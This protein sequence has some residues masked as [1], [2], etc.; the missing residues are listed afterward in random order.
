M[1]RDLN[2]CSIDDSSVL[3]EMRQDRFSH[4]DEAKDI[5]AKRTFQLFW[6]E[7]FNSLDFPLLGHIV[8]KNIHS[9]ES[10]HGFKCNALAKAGLGDIAGKP[11]RPSS[12]GSNPTDCKLRV[13]MLVQ[14]DNA[15]VS[16]LLGEQDGHGP[17]D[18]AV[19]A[20]DNRYFAF[21]LSAS[22]VF[23]IFIQRLR[24]HRRFRSGQPLH[25]G[26]QG[27]GFFIS[28]CWHNYLPYRVKRLFSLCDNAS[29]T[30]TTR[31]H[32]FLCAHFLIEQTRRCNLQL[33][34]SASLQLSET[35]Q[36]GG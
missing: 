2:R 33:F 13:L 8:H 36:E 7:I 18:A 12:Q 24:T 26:W 15:D 19:T 1:A 34:R 23:R 17:A 21:K 3:L 10:V 14:I 5:C 29:L 32:C 31:T 28:F 9:T 20:G 35:R 16:A 11:E 6:I 4:V 22:V 25:L 30:C 27:L